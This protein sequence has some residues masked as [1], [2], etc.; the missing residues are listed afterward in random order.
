VKKEGNATYGRMKG[1]KT[2]IIVRLEK[3]TN[4]SAVAGKRHQ[5]LCVLKRKPT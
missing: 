2:P 4:P 3:E 5:S 1:Q